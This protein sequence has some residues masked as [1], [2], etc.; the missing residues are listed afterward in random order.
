MPDY[1]SQDSESFAA[2]AN[3]RIKDSWLCSAWKVNE[4]LH[5]ERVNRFSNV[6]K[7]CLLSLQ[8]EAF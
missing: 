5:K 7:W 4:K 6:I 8:I 1:I 2:S 3:I